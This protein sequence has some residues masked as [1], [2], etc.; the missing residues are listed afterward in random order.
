MIGAH[1]EHADGA[2]ALPRS[3]DRPRSRPGCRELDLVA[4]AVAVAVGVKR[5]TVV[6]AGEH[7]A[8]TRAPNGASI[9]W[10]R[11]AVTW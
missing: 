5:R 9:S 8:T 3:A 6:E 11:H 10:S 7:R 1:A 4:E 2:S